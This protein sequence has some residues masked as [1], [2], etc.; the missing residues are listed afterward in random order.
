MLKNSGCRDLDITIELRSRPRRIILACQ[1]I[2][3]SSSTPLVR[4]RSS[5]QIAGTTAL[6]RKADLRAASF[7]RPRFHRL[8]LQERTTVH[9]DSSGPNSRSDTHCTAI[10][11]EWE[12]PFA[13]S[14]IETWTKVRAGASA[15]ADQPTTAP[16]RFNAPTEDSC[17]VAGP[18][19]TPT[20]SGPPR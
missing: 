3:N 13:E 1:R 7:A 20:A 8:H 16:P 6:P 4:R 17:R 19:R 18:W 11:G 15:I 9:R 12:E 2:E 5:E 10:L 14:R